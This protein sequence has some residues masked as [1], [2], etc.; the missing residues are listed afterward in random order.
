MHP[1]TFEVLDKNSPFT[2]YPF[3]PVPIFDVTEISKN[4]PLDFSSCFKKPYPKNHSFLHKFIFTL[5]YRSSHEVFN[6]MQLLCEFQDVYSQHKSDL[7]VVDTHFQITLK[8]GA[9]LKKQCITK[10][11]F[12]YRDQIQQNLDA[13]EQNCILERVGNKCCRILELGAEI[14]NPITIL[15]KRGT[16]KTDID[17]RFLNAINDVPKN[18]SS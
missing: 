2:D 5:C 1:D 3:N 18:H 6:L 11:A 7:E 10:V 17:I 14:S 8:P 4:P 15:P 16:Y 13:L 12:L 9:E